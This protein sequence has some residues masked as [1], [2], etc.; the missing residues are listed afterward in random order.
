MDPEDMTRWEQELGVSIIVKKPYWGGGGGT[1]IWE[2]PSEIMDPGNRIITHLIWKWDRWRFSIVMRQPMRCINI[3]SNKHCI[4]LVNFDCF[5]ASPAQKPAGVDAD[6]DESDGEIGDEEGSSKRESSRRV[7]F[8]KTV[9]SMD[10]SGKKD[11]RHKKLDPCGL[12]I[13]EKI[14]TSKKARRE[15]IDHAYNRYVYGE[16]EGLPEWFA[17]SERIHCRRI[18][19]VTKE[20]VE[21]YKARLREINARPIKKIAQAKARKKMR[22]MRKLEKLKRKAESIGDTM[23][24]SEKEKYSQLKTLY[25]KAGLDG[26]RKK[27]VAYVVAKKGLRGKRIKRPRGLKGPYKVVDT[28]MKA[29]MRGKKALD[30]RRKKTAKKRQ[31]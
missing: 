15:V 31:K 30:A 22:Y 24:T 3:K 9:F 6:S 21:K 27:Q 17:R 1:G 18:M 7:S 20:Q 25:K 29:D 10:D 26:K 23:D 28:R 19:P 13:G 4:K 2:D 11:T 16:E 8:N 5:L 14:A 12:A